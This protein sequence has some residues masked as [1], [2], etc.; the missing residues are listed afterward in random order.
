MN[1]R[2]KKEKKKKEAKNQVQ[3]DVVPEEHVAPVSARG[4]ETRSSSHRL[5]LFGQVPV[6]SAGA[7]REKLDE[8][9][10]GIRRQRNHH[11]TRRQRA[12]LRPDQPGRRR[13][14]LS[15]RA[16]DPHE[17]PLESEF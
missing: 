12:L 6:V 10:T 11:S 16:P 14:H 2:K 17:Q 9:A 5:R 4:G 13:K 3:R 7:P 8:D 1:N 15:R